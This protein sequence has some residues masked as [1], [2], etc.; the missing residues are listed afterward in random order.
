MSRA[1]ML[2]YINTNIF[3]NFALLAH[4]GKTGNT[5]TH[6][7]AKVAQPLPGRATRSRLF[8]CHAL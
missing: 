6:N 2:F 8:D 7:S 1:L 3:F 5:L 4:T